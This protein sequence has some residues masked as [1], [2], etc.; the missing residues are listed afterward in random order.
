MQM[1][2]ESV[3]QLTRVRCQIQDHLLQLF[4]HHLPGT[5]VTAELAIDQLFSLSDAAND[6]PH[7]QIGHVN[8]DW[9]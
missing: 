8:R 7:N 9:L 5:L 3:P 2:R 4:H 6:S 1:R